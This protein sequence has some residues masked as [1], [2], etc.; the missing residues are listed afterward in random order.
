MTEIEPLFS[1]HFLSDMLRETN[2]QILTLIENLGRDEILNKKTDDWCDEFEIKFSLKV[3]ELL[4]DKI[5]IDT[6]DAKVRSEYGGFPITGT[7]YTYRV[8]FVGEAGL[9]CS[10]PSIYS[11]SRPRAAIL[12]EHLQLEYSAAGHNADQIKNAFAAD[13]QSIKQYLGRLAEDVKVYNDGLRRTVTQKI[14]DRRNKILKDKGIAESL[15][16]SLRRSTDFPEVLKA[17]LHRKKL[18]V[19]KSPAV[20]KPLPP[21]VPEY[22]LSMDDYEQILTV[23]KSMVK[24]MERSP[25]SFKQMDEPD[26]RNQLLVPLNAQFEGGAT[27]ETF[28]GEGKTDILIRVGDKNIFI[29]ECKIWH[30]P[31]E[32][33]DAIDQLLGYTTWRDTKTAIFVFNR[34]KNFSGVIGSIRETVPKHPNYKKMVSYQSE[35]DFRCVLK[36]KTDASRELILTVL[37]FDVPS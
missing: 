32:L 19:Q 37:A 11:M 36:N 30:G 1:R 17:P 18:S 20:E 29:G 21:Y 27:G 6:D 3:P 5:D 10:C 16:Y 15:G 25:Q 24:V 23:S 9:F 28:N 12:S 33:L 14:E 22:E 26:L 13:L 7:K 35:T 31:K 34:N 4:E 8:P 2:Q